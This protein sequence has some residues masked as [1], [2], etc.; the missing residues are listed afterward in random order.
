MRAALLCGVFSIP[1]MAEDPVDRDAP[2]S[3]HAGNWLVIEPRAKIQL[4]F[5]GFRPEL[6]DKRNIFQGRRLR[7]G[8]DGTLLQ[9]F[10]FSVRVETNRGTP[11]FRDVFLKYHRFRALQMQAGRFKIPFGLD[12]MTDSGELDFMQRSRIGSILAPGR[13]TGAM[14][15][16]EASESKVYY[17]AGVFQ[18]DGRNSEIED[19]AAA[20]EY[21]PGG[22][23]TVAARVTIQ[24]GAFLPALAALRNLRIGAAFTSS[25]L[26]TGLSSLP[27]LTV[28]NQVFFPRM[29]VNGTRLRRGAELSWLVR[30]LSIQ[31]EFMDVRDQRLGQ[32]LNSE[33]LPPLRSEGW[34]LSATHPVLGHLDTRN[35]RGFLRSILPGTGFGLIEAAARYETIHFGS[36]SS[37]GFSPSRNPRAANVIGNDDDAWTFGINWYASRYLKS[38]FNAVR[39]TL[40]D[41]VSAPLSGQSRYWTLEG[42]VQFFFKTSRHPLH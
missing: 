27:G 6:D 37:I 8:V 24:P 1:A 5:S 28:S 2:L 39:E 19:F 41:P 21:L 30:S 35:D 34:Y 23:R 40:S 31:G 25:D 3:M 13:E 22:D 7:F 10:D 33:D 26:A 4:D 29:Y 17:A 42:R 20:N 18:H 9:D 14:V 32:G 12:Q 16:G 36:A 15:L 11:E 38:Q